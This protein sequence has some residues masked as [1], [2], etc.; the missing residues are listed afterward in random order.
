[1]SSQ[2]I[3]WFWKSHLCCTIWGLQCRRMRAAWQS[4]LSLS[5]KTRFFLSD[6][7]SAARK[8]GQV[9]VRHLHTDRHSCLAQPVHVGGQISKLRHTLC[10]DDLL[11]S[12]ALRQL[13]PS[14]SAV[15]RSL[16]S[17][18][19]LSSFGTGELPSCSI[20]I[21]TYI[22]RRCRCTVLVWRDV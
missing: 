6:A 7:H 15:K 8:E 11:G 5:V 13:F 20:A 17:V 14:A 2:G 19:P 22:S 4:C 3:T 9:H 21:R 12:F 16:L 10:F 1:M 18:S